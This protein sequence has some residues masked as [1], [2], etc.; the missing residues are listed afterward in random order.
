MD[1]A[2]K[3]RLEDCKSELKALLL[4]EVILTLNFEF[5]FIKAYFKL[6]IDAMFNFFLFTW[7]TRD[8]P[9]RVN[10]YLHIVIFF[11]VRNINV[12]NPES[13]YSTF[14]KKVNMCYVPIFCY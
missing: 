12:F 6:T 11:S 3:L 7:V 14:V 9:F 2:D 4:E 8:L 10:L 1:S 13:V 5:V